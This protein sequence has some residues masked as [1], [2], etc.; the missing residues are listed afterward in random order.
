MRYMFN[1][2]QGNIGAKA[3]FIYAALC[4]AEPRT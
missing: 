4:S 2:D 1:A 3:G